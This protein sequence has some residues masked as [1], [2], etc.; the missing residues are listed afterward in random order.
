MN[1]EDFDFLNTIPVSVRITIAPNPETP[2]LLEGGLHLDPKIIRMPTLPDF[3]E[4][5]LSLLQIAGKRHRVDGVG[6]KFSD[7][8]FYIQISQNVWQTLLP[9]AFN[10]PT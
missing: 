10:T 1:L 6:Y 7:N 9:L 5:K 8:V 4:E 3:I 2:Y